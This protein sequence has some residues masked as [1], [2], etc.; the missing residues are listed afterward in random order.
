[1][2]KYTEDYLLAFIE[3]LISL[4]LIIGGF[5]LTYWSVLLGVFIV[6]CGVVLYAMSKLSCMKIHDKEQREKE[7]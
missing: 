7:S 5:V 3:C 6:A 1:M 4:F 2:N